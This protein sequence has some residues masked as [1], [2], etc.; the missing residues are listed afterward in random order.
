MSLANGNLKGKGGREKLAQMGLRRAKNDRAWDWVRD[1]ANNVRSYMRAPGILLPL[2]DNKELLQKIVELN[3]KE[4]L[5]DLL[6][7][8]S[9]DALAYAERFKAIFSR[10]AERHGNSTDA[11]DMLDSI[12]ISQRYQQFMASY[13]A[14][15]MPLLQEILEILE[16]AGVDTTNIRAVA[17]SEVVYDLYK[18]DG[19]SKETAFSSSATNK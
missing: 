16:S 8:L 4:A 13:E 1:I 15:V 11:D 14:V 17:S 9:T 7:R 10:H 2:L 5:T 18:G 6:S 12:D 19:E 3:K